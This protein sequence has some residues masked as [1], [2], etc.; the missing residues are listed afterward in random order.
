MDR[1]GRISL[2]NVFLFLALAAVALVAWTFLPYQWHYLKMKEVTKSA[3]LEWDAW[4]NKARAEEKLADLLDRRSIPDYI[5]PEDCQFTEEPVAIY[6][7][8]CAWKVDVYY[9]FT[10]KF[11]TLSFET[12]ETVDEK[13]LVQ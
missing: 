2:M 11:K 9:P 13:G 7:V 6:T 4:D 3:V 8:R 5:L 12:L 10:K 1:R